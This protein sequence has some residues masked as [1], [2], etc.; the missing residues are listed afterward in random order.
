MK[1]YTFLLLVLGLMHATHAQEVTYNVQDMPAVRPAAQINLANIHQEYFPSLVYLEAPNPNGDSYRAYLERVKQGIDRKYP[2]RPQPKA[3]RSTGMEPL[4][5]QSFFGNTGSQG[6]P[7]DNHLAV[8]NDGQVVSVMNFSMLVT[9]TVGNPI[10]EVSLAS[11]FGPLNIPLDE[12]DPKIMYD[13]VSDRW[14]LICL[15]YNARAERTNVLMAFSASNDATGTWNL[16]DFNGDPMN[17]TTWS[18]YP[19]VSIN[20]TELF[21]TTNSIRY[22]EPW[23]TGFSET[24]IWQ[25]KLADGYNNQPITPRVW[26]GIQFGGLPIRNLCPVKG[27]FGYY[28]PNQYF[29]SNRNFDVQNN[30]IFLVEVTDSIGAAGV[31]LK[32]TPRNADNNYG[33][34]PNAQ[35]PGAGTG[36]LATNDAR[37]LH[38]LTLDDH[39]QFVGNSIDTTTGFS[40]IYH[41]VIENVSSTPTVKAGL[42]TDGVRDFGYPAIAYTGIDSPDREAIIVFSH[43]SETEYPGISA[44]YYDNDGTYSDFI[45]IKAGT[46]YIDAI[47]LGNERWGDYTGNQR[48]YDEPG[49]VWISS[50]HGYGAR[51]AGVWMAK[52]TRPNVPFTSNTPEIE[53]MPVKVYPNPARNWVQAEFE[54]PEGV[55]VNIRLLDASGRVVRTFQN[56]PTRK[57][58]W[59][60]FRFTTEPLPAGMYLLQIRTP[61]RLLAARKIVV[62]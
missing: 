50:T 4:V 33:V 35:Q 30:A 12:F 39:I 42:I 26:S 46:N 1:K 44:V 37:I 24:I 36:T 41:G 61:D 43:S 28:G 2:R 6:I 15:S 56:A 11:I 55:S 32:V 59:A 3:R 54:I 49:S 21:L 62:E 8:S 23:Q 31:R 20:A 17:T 18:D 10:R 34:P 29:L 45:E 9:D 53:Q 57:S 13:V 38:A 48:V 47:P 40:A 14:V 52:L 7:L 16:Y 60:R 51:R 27:A 19:M 25:M 5:E 22:N 58:G